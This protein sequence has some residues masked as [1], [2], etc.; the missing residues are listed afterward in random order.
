[1][2]AS[3]IYHE[4]YSLRCWRSAILGAVLHFSLRPQNRRS[5][6]TQAMNHIHIVSDA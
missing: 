1:M 6:A 5:P 3:M 2:S 4:P